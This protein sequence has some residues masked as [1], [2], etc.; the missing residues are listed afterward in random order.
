MRTAY[1]LADL[2]GLHVHT[3]FYAPANYAQDI[4]GLA[5][6][7]ALQSFITSQ[8]ESPK[9]AAPLDISVGTL[10]NKRPVF[11]AK[12]LVFHAHGSFQGLFNGIRV[13]SVRDGKLKWGGTRGGTCFSRQGEQLQH[14]CGHK[15]GKWVC[16][17]V[18]RFLMFHSRKNNQHGGLALACIQEWLLLR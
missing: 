4:A 5:Q 7:G 8:D 12:G 18:R 13:Q 10:T 15:I 16:N 14:G 3:Y 17:Q 9:G 6:R 11:N 2:A 1:N